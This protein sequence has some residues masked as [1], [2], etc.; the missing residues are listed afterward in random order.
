MGNTTTRRT[1][2]SKN[3]RTRAQLPSIGLPQCQYVQTLLTKDE[4]DR[5]LAEL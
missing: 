2:G 1:D 3:R 5:F 4:A